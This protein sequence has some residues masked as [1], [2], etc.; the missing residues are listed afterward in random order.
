MTVIKLVLAAVAAT[1]LQ[2]PPLEMFQL[3]HTHFASCSPTTKGLLMTS[4]LKLHLQQPGD[5]A[6]K[7]QVAGIFDRYSETI[8]P[9]LQ[10]RA[11][12]YKRLMAAPQKAQEC[13]LPMPVWEGRESALLKRLQVR[14][15]PAG[16]H[17]LLCRC[18][19]SGPAQPG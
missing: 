19:C 3:L 11:V 15:W 7:Q 4:F 17:V 16:P 2:T 18:C 13:V 1:A 14:R 9:D 10:Q 8:D 12:E 5:E 6:L